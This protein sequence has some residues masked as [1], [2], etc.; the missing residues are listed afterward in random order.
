ML[1]LEKFIL[2][3]DSVNPYNEK[4]LRSTGGMIYNINIII[5]DI[6]EEIIKL[7][8]KGI[9]IIGTSLQKSISLT[10]VEKTDK[11]AIILG[12]EGNGISDE[13][14]ALVDKNIYIKMNENCES[15]NVAVSGS[16]ILY[17]LSK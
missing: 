13:I 12:N 6:Q 1:C 4:V 2:S 15:L 5:G 8:E 9:K 14:N 16:I 11:Y 17:E 7:K 3:K 10:D